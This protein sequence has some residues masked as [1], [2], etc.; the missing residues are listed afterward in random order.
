MT[1]QHIHCSDTVTGVHVQ[2][3]TR[4]KLHDMQELRQS[5]DNYTLQAHNSLDSY[6]QF[7]T[8]LILTSHVNQRI[9]CVN[10]TQHHSRTSHYANRHVFLHKKQTA[11][12]V[13]TLQRD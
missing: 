8:E 9:T 5:H 10:V 1:V 2:K 13:Y 3:Y 12:M 4:N 7:S 6:Q 11:I